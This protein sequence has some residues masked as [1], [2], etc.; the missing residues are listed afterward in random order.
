MDNET[1]KTKQSER[2]RDQPLSAE[3]EQIYSY[4]TINMATKTESNTLEYDSISIVT[5]GKSD[6]NS[7]ARLFETKHMAELHTERFPGPER[8]TMTP[9]E[10]ININ[11]METT[12]TSGSETTN[13]LE[14][15]K[16]ETNVTKEETDLQTLIASFTS[17]SIYR[18]TM[19]SANSNEQEAMPTYEAINLETQRRREGIEIDMRITPDIEDL[20]TNIRSEPTTAETR[21]K[22]ETTVEVQT[23]QTKVQKARR[24]S[25][26]IFDKEKML[27]FKSRNKRRKKS[28]N[29]NS[30]KLAGPKSGPSVSLETEQEDSQETTG[31][32]DD[33]LSCTSF[34]RIS[35]ETASTSS[36][37]KQRG[38]K[39]NTNSEP[40]IST[41]IGNENENDEKKTKYVFERRRVFNLAKHIVSIV[42]III[43][44]V[45]D[46]VEYGEMNKRGNYSTVAERRVNNVEYTVCLSDIYHR[47][48]TI[49]SDSDHLYYIPN[50]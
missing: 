41:Q 46:W 49:F 40:A 10:A 5:T 33:N 20:Q 28:D 8:D 18:E 30:K 42:L 43:D 16:P 25:D 29:K 27:Q 17:Q 48:N 36:G 21:I 50:N 9:V 35:P 19:I 31:F 34:G 22:F 37:V 4:N 38:A 45:F 11:T 32:K 12:E 23:S 7:C 2:R 39:Y 26:V 6:S 24:K 44:S 47:G 3:V 14:T 15:T 1:K 13:A